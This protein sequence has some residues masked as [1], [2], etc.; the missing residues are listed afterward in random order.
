[1]AIFLMQLIDTCAEGDGVRNN[2]NKKRLLLYFKSTNSFSKYAIEMFTSIA[3]IEAIVSEQM[4]ERLT[5][6]R[7]V[8]WHGGLGKNIAK[9]TAQE[10]CV[11]VSKAWERTRQKNQSS[12]LQCLDLVYMT[13]S[14]HLTKPQTST[15][16]LMHTAQEVLLRMR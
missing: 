13:L 12:V 8:D 1:M 16:G 15:R 4:A 6:E 3:Q 10:V 5:W 11:K 2:I 7:F 14:H 9:D